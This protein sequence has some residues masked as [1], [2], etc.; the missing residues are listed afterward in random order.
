MINYL[1]CAQANDLVKLG[2]NSSIRN[3]IFNLWTKYLQ[4]IGV[5]FL[6]NNSLKLNESNIKWER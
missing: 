6:P 3:I 4:K 1:L 5:A 2:V